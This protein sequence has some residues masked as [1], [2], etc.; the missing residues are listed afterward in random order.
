MTLLTTGSKNSAYRHAREFSAA[1]HP[2]PERR[3]PIGQI[4]RETVDGLK[5]TLPVGRILTIWEPPPGIPALVASKRLVIEVLT[6]VLR[7]AVNSAAAEVWLTVRQDQAVVVI[8]V[9]DDGRG[10]EPADIN[11]VFVPAVRGLSER[12]APHRVDRDLCLSHRLAQSVGGD[13][14]AVADPAA[15]RVEIRLPLRTASLPPEQARPGELRRPASVQP[16]GR[17]IPLS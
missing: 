9:A 7:N 6:P 17:L 5:G 10:F 2:P 16:E 13:L 4:L 14:T 3:T 8:E 12:Y 1:P 11:D 15:G